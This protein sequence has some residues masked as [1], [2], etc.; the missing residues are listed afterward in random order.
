[1][2]NTDVRGAGQKHTSTPSSE[3]GDE[4][5]TM[6][7]PQPGFTGRKKKKKQGKFHVMSCW[8]SP[9]SVAKV[10]QVF[11][12]LFSSGL[13]CILCKDVLPNTTNNCG[14]APVEILMWWTDLVHLESAHCE[15]SQGAR[16]FFYTSCAL[17]RRHKLP[18]Q[19]VCERN[20]N[21]IKIHMMNWPNSTGFYLQK[22]IT[23][24][25]WL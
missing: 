10:L 1:M 7:L 24:S 13:E 3:P 15:V 4:L 12:K 5:V 20:N 9:S 6:N 21:V 19:T 2:E 18:T 25:T 11:I 16:P 23:E 17:F 14:T 8:L 22:H